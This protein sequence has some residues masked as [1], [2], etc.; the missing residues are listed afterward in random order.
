MIL[1]DESEVLRS[2]EEEDITEN[3]TDEEDSSTDEN[4][5]PPFQVQDPLDVVWNATSSSFY[6][7]FWYNKQR[8]AIF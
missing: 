7:R 6:E 5:I 3:C 2:L 8:C 4:K 1:D